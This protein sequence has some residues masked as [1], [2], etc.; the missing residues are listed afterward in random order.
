MAVGRLGPQ[1]RR[2]RSASWPTSR[3]ATSGRIGAGPAWFANHDIFKAV[4]RPVSSAVIAAAE[5]LAGR[6]VLDVGCGT[7]VLS[8]LVADRGGTPVGADISAT[9]IDGARQLYPELRFEVVDVQV[10]DLAA[11]APGGFDAVDLGVRGDVLRRPG[12]RVRQ[13]RRGHEAA[14]ARWRSPAGG[15]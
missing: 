11:L 7:G 9:M 8:R 6:V 5:P 14:G 13:H 2:L 15:R 3:C 10:A 4:F 1:P 12:R